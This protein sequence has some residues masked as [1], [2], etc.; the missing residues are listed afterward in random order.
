[1]KEVEQNRLSAIQKVIAD[2]EKK[3]PGKEDEIWN[4][5]L[6]C[7]VKHSTIEPESIRNEI[8]ENLSWVYNIRQ[9]AKE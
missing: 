5:V 4:S 2:F 7:L 8:A 3:F 1:M 9:Q 6:V